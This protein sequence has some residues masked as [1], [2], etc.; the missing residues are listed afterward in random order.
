[1]LEEYSIMSERMTLNS[2]ATGYNSDVEDNDISPP[3]SLKLFDKNYSNKTI[4]GKDVWWSVAGK[5][6]LL[7]ETH[8]MTKGFTK[9]EKNAA[10]IACVSRNV[11]NNKKVIENKKSETLIRR[12]LNNLHISDVSETDSRL[13]WKV[14]SQKDIDGDS[15][16]LISI[17]LLNTHIACMLIDLAPS[18]DALNGVNKL[19]QTALHIAAL[20]GNYTVARRLLVAGAKVDKRDFLLNTA[21]HIAVRKGYIKV[22]KQLMTPVTYLEAKMN[23]Y[24]IPYQKI[25]QNLEMFNGNG[26]TCLHIAARKK[27]KILID[28]LIDNEADVNVR[29]LKSGKTILHYFAESDDV[30][31][32]KYVVSKSRINVNITTYSGTTAAELA[33]SKGHFAI[34]YLLLSTGSNGATPEFYFN[35]LN[36]CDSEDS[37]SSV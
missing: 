10:N 8:L 24:E 18:Y 32:V 11:Q 14:I 16:L 19:F 4:K 15:L 13:V 5:E 7:D 35:N 1:M 21:L 2:V 37:D 12:K 27:N 22:V 26:E 17:I 31:M 6:C 30:E 9:D 23:R 33:H 36:D 28:L 25:P 29:E 20:T 34:A 3:K